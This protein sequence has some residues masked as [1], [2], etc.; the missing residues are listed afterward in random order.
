MPNRFMRAAVLIFA[1]VASGVGGTLIYKV[2]PAESAWFPPCPLRVLTGLYCPGCGSGRALH[3]L[4]HG[5]VMAASGFN[6]LMVMMLPVM[7]VWAS[8]KAWAVCTGRNP[9]WVY[10]LG[11][12]YW[13]LP[14]ILMLYFILRNLSFYPFTTLAPPS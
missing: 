4:L 2:N 10:V 1:L 11:R 5:E 12:W 14:A 9:C 3:H 7:V 13:F 8:V 6:L